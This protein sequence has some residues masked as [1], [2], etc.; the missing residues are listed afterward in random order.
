MRI[1]LSKS[2]AVTL[3]LLLLSGCN[4]SDEESQTGITYY[5]ENRDSDNNIEEDSSETT[6]KEDT[7][8]DEQDDN[9]FTLKNCGQEYY[10][11]EVAD[12]LKACVQCHNDSGIASG[13]KLVF[14]DESKIESNENFNTLKMYILNTG[15]K[16]IQKN[17]GTKNHVGGSTFSTD[18]SAKLENL[19]VKLN[20]PQ[21]CKLGNSDSDT[22]DI[23][24]VLNQGFLHSVWSYE[25]SSINEIIENGVLLNPFKSVE[26]LT[27]VLD[28]PVNVDD[29]YV[30]RVQA[31]IT[32]KVSG[33]Y[34]FYSSVDDVA[35]VWLSTNEKNKNAKKIIE[36]TRWTRHNDFKKYAQ[37]KSQKIRLEKGKAYYLDIVAYEN[38]GGDNLSLAWSKVNNGNEGALEV[39]PANVITSYPSSHVHNPGES[40]NTVSND[41]MVD[42]TKD[43]STDK[44][45][46]DAVEKPKD[47]SVDINNDDTTDDMNND[48]TDKQIDIPLM[49]EECVSDFYQQEIA[50]TLNTCVAC[51]KDSGIASGTK[52]VLDEVSGLDSNKNFNTLKAYLLTTGRKIIDKND[53]TKNHVGGKL[54]DPSKSDKMSTM[55]EYVSNPTMCKSTDTITINTSGIPLASYQSTLES[56]AMLILN[57]KASEQELNQAQNEAGLDNVLDSYMRTDAFYN[58]VRR[59]FNDILLTDGIS[60]GDSINAIRGTKFRDSA[61]WYE[62]YRDDD[63]ATYNTARAA[64]EFGARKAPLELIVNVM[65][66]NRAFSEILTADY[67]MVNPYS[68]RSYGIDGDGFAFEN[69]SATSEFSQHDFKEVKLE[70]I[71]HAGILSDTMFLRKYPTTRTNA[72]RHRSSMVQLMFLNTDIEG[73]SNRPLDSNRPDENYQHPT[74]E[75]PDCT[76]CHVVMEPIS[77]AFKNY[78]DGV[79]YTQR[80]W[81]DNMQRPGFD[82]NNPLPAENSADALQWLAKNIVNDERF[83]RSVVHMFYKALSGREPL[84]IGAQ[85]PSLE[86][87]QAISFE[88]DIFKE[89]QEAFV[90]SNMNAKVLLKS[91]IK[92]PLFRGSG[93][94]DVEFN[95]YIDKSISTNILLSPE[96]LDEKIKNLTGYYWTDRNYYTDASEQQKDGKRHYL[97]EQFNITYGG[98]D[99]KDITQRA[100]ETNALMASLQM[101]MAAEMSSRVTPIEFFYEKSKRKIFPYVEKDMEPVDE[102]SVLSI[103]KNIQ[104]MY[105]YLLNEEHDIESVEVLEVYE[106]FTESIK[107]GQEQIANKTYPSYLRYWVVRDPKTNEDVPREKQIRYDQKW[108]IGSWS[109]VLTYMLSDYKFLY[110]VR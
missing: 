80:A 26:T 30:H 25:A 14:D 17:D 42:N 59:S 77:G 19:I 56:V 32:P 48:S 103:K 93:M 65:K 36:Q 5:D 18:T 24:Q 64:A 58:W 108:V 23:S 21:E 47:D 16:I 75:N 1:V 6:K 99:S 62:S 68:A 91:L 79:K 81:L 104:H 20:N 78:R 60:G 13:T 70:G 45:K 98:I 7:S 107:A 90:N 72:N 82:I 35:T 86:L 84:R 73:L 52:L 44:P 8:G 46:D 95:A 69:G 63:R 27:G 76:I 97:K 49:N 28:T 101:R 74:M 22:D 102:A 12:S 96:A 92:S 39:L 61:R 55:L 100:Q 57:R 3:S 67:M 9:D 105:K 15:S 85:T 109:L 34:Y 4:S 66:K 10:I 33:E 94:G 38:G 71:P 89:V 40:E 31:Y 37:Q 87:T 11:E 51:H 88:N 83:A 2:I 41:D 54:F 53:G 43:E 29:Y 106:L 50:S 110:E